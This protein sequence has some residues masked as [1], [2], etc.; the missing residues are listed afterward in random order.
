MGHRYN[1]DDSVKYRYYQIPKALLLSKYT[2]LTNDD[3]VV[4]AILSDRLQLSRKNVWVNAHRELYIYFSAEH[5]A[6]LLNVSRKT[7][8]RIFRHLKDAGLLES[9]RQGLGKP[10]QLYVCMPDVDPNLSYTLDKSGNSDEPEVDSPPLKLDPTDGPGMPPNETDLNDPDLNDPEG[11][12]PEVNIQT[13]CAPTQI[14]PDIQSVRMYCQARG[15][16]LDAEEFCDYYT[17]RGWH[18]VEDWTAAVRQWERY[19]LRFRKA[20]SRN[21]VRTIL[22]DTLSR[23]DKEVVPDG[24]V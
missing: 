17:A 6:E 23:C 14:P 7:V 9:E 15:N 13:M 1:S 16:S 22:H 4:Y 20:H 12:E 21:D 10:N 8:Y 5:L 19:D 3:R 2:Q 11:S 18:E 24:L